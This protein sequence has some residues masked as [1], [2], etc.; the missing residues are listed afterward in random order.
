M[1]LYKPEDCLY[2]NNGVA[3]SQS[4][5]FTRIWT[6]LVHYHNVVCE[7]DARPEQIINAA[8]ASNELESYNC[9]ATNHKLL[10]NKS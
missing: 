2:S 8:K 5:F 6:L 3:V 1:S 9:Y 7:I 4:V 10:R